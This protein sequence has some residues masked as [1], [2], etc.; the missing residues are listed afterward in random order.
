MESLARQR[1]QRVGD[2]DENVS[3]LWFDKGPLLRAGELQLDI[4][5][6][7]KEQCQGATVGVLVVLDIGEF[8]FGWLVVQFK[9]GIARLVV[10]MVILQSRTQIKSV[11]QGRKQ[12]LTDDMAVSRQL[13]E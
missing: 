6:L 5:L 7:V 9:A 8:A 4:P 12:D 3:G 1:L 13:L 2:V 11:G 10:A